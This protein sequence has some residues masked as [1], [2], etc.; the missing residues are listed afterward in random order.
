MSVPSPLFFFQKPSPPYT[1]LMK[2]LEL[3]L[4]DKKFCDS[5]LENAEA[6]DTV[7]QLYADLSPLSL[8]R[9][10]L[11][12]W[13]DKSFTPGQYKLLVLDSI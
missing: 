11:N 13:L 6:A 9:L 8:P 2:F 1:I 7:L 5:S 4:Y 12:S 3:V 10:L